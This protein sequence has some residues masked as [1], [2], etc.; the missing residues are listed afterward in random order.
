MKKKYIT[1]E[2]SI[3]PFKDIDIYENSEVIAIG[4]DFEYETCLNE[5]KIRINKKAEVLFLEEVPCDNE[6]AVIYGPDYY[7]N[8]ET[9]K[10]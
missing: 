4:K 9:S 2:P 6:M 8:H 7:T 1:T 3:S 5:F 10:K